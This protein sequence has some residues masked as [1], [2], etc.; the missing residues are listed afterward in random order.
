M[1]FVVF[2]DSGSGFGIPG[3]VLLA[4]LVLSHGIVAGATYVA[5]RRRRKLQ[6][7]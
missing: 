4:G 6:S 2:R 5:A 7:S 3:A 1:R